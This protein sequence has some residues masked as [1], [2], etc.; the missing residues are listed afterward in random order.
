[1]QLSDH[2]SLAEMTV[3]LHRDISNIPDEAVLGVLRDTAHRMEEVRDLLG[4]AI[5]VSS[6]YRCPALNRAVGGVAFSAHV[7]GRAVDFNCFGYGDPLAI[8]HRIATSALRFDQLIEEGTWV[9]LSF[10]PRMRREVL[11]KG[12]GGGYVTGLRQT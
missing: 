12:E 6:A 10:D 9:H 2:F 5:T 11:T 3:T 7:T 8:C 4:G 1:M